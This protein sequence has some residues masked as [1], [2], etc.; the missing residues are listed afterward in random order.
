MLYVKVYF[1]D[2]LWARVDV[3]RALYAVAYVHEIDVPCTGGIYPVSPS[4]SCTGFVFSRNLPF[5]VDGGQFYFSTDSTS[6]SA[7]H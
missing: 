5:L 2:Y 4:R 1:V 7:L 6:L 3:I